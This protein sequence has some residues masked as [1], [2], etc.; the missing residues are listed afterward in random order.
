MR[1]LAFGITHDNV[2]ASDEVS[3]PLVWIPDF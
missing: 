3:T 1:Q 2:P